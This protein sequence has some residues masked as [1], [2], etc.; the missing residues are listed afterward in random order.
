MRRTSYRSEGSIPATA[1]AATAETRLRES[2]E[3]INPAEG[4]TGGYSDSIHEQLKSYSTPA[5]VKHSSNPIHHHIAPAFGAP[6]MKADGLVHRGIP[7]SLVAG[8]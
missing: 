2:P 5:T 6:F 7:P 3:P 1:F 4:E 8:C